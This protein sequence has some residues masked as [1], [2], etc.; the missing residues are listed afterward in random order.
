MGWDVPR[1]SRIRTSGG[2]HAVLAAESVAAGLAIALSAAQGRSPLA[3][4]GWL[5][6]GHALASSLVSLGLGVLVGTATI[7]ATRV[8]VANFGWARALHLAL[9][10]SVHGAG[11]GVL[12]VA[13]LASATAEE[14]LFRGLL[15]P[16]VG[17]VASSLLFGAL[18]QIRGPARW[19]WMAWA[20]LMGLIFAGIFSVTGSLAGP[21]VAHA[22]INLSNLWF[23]RDTDP[24]AAT[25]RRRGPPL[26]GLLTRP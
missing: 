12:V 21:I 8:L 2:L 9:R 23:L 20:T 3:C 25:L 16:L 11:N 24:N 26:G 15:V 22:A 18:H 4:E 19:G 10:P 6:G 17:V 14:L 13:A 7:R 5:G 1:S